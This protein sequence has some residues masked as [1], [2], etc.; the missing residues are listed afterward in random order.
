MSWTPFAIQSWKRIAQN[1][2]NILEGDKS[3]YDAIISSAAATRATRP[4]WDY[5]GDKTGWNIAR[6]DE[7]E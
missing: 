4:V 1:V 5:L 7:E 3:F 6:N 2:F